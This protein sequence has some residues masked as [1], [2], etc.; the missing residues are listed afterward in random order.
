MT[1]DNRRTAIEQEMRHS[2]A[3]LKAAHALRDLGLCNDA[4]SRLYYALFHAFGDVE[5]LV[6]R[7]RG[8][9]QQGGWLSPEPAGVAR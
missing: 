1:E 7:I 3:A 5:P 9:L 6:V 8:L 4:L 2:A